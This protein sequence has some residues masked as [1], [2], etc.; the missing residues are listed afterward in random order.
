MLMENNMW[1]DQEKKRMV[2]KYP[3]VKD[4]SVLSN[5]YSQAVKMA[6][7]LEKRL[8]RDD[9]FGGGK[10]EFIDKMISEIIAAVLFW[11]LQDHGNTFYET[12]VHGKKRGN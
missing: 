7:S 6:T 11:K 2:V 5:T 12:E 8:V 10:N 1:V 9:G 3:V 4:P